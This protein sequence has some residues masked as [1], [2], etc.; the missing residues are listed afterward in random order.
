MKR[1]SH[2]ISILVISLAFGVA[3]IAQAPPS[4]SKNKL[5]TE[6]VQVMKMDRQFPEMM[7]TMLKGMESTYPIGFEAAVDSMNLSPEQK[8]AA[9]ATAGDRFIAFSQK[10]R[11][12]M[13][14]AIDYN[15]YIREAIYP[16]YD[17]F[18]SEQELRDLIA[19]YRTPTGQ[20][21]V[22]TL[23]ALLTE[24]NIAAKEK[25]LPQLL[26]LIEA[27]LKE[28]FQQIEPLPKPKSK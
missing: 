7:D 12:R 6:L 23:P 19:F 27:L 25:F 17:K 20:K 22:D 8:K 10:F 15:K 11:K 3:V 28:E 18:Y 4:E 14:E 13:A 1:I 21:V 24:S 26:P 2:F 9:K 5:V 16:L